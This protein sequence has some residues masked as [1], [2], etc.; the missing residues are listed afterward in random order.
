[1]EIREACEQLMLYYEIVSAY[2]KQQELGKSV[3]PVPVA[4]ISGY[5]NLTVNVAL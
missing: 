1:M 5:Q 4:A 2:I 3:R